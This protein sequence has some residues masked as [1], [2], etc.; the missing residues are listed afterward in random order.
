MA[1]L[2]LFVKM[3]EED[4]EVLINLFKGKEEKD[5]KLLLESVKTLEKLSL[6]KEKARELVKSGTVPSLLELCQ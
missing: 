6:D 1:S 3:K 5:H 2:F 4:K